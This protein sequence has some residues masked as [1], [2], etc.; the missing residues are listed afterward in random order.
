MPRADEVAEDRPDGSV[1]EADSRR[2]RGR[3]MQE[4]RITIRGRNLALTTER[5]YL[6]WIRMFIRYHRYRHPA[7]MGGAEVD[8][9]LSWLAAWRRVSPKTQ[10]VA[11]NALVF[12]YRHHLQVELGPLAYRR[13]RPKPRVPVVLTHEEAMAIIERLTGRVQT[14]VQLLYGAGLRQ[15]ECCMLRIKDVD[16]GMGEIVVRNGKGAK[17]RRTLLP[18]TLRTKL[19]QQ[20]EYVR[21]LHAADLAAGYGEVYIPEALGRKYPN[22]RFET[23]WQ[24]LFPNRA[25]SPDPRSGVIRRHHVHPSWIRKS[26]K[27]ARLAAGIDKHVTCHTFRHS[28]AT[29]LLEQGY[30]LRTIQELLGHSD[31]ATTEIYTHVLNRGARG[32]SGPLG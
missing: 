19:E 20:V 3:F 21:L 15:A 30:D 17:D 22:V 4:V 5:T 28:F 18:A 2:V 27:R 7:T 23:G 11:L 16:F 8:A 32:V 24:F 29:R 12:L 26:I 14:F 1:S 6:R 9:F 10:A 13:P 25:P 31:I